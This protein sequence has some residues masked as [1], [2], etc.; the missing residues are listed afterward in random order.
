MTGPAPPLP[1]ECI[2]RDLRARLS[3]P[4]PGSPVKKSISL[5]VCDE[6]SDPGGKRL[7]CKSL[8]V[9]SARVRIRAV[10]EL[11][12]DPARSAAI[13]R[14]LLL[15]EQRHVHPV[16]QRAEQPAVTLGV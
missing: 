10:R 8:D 2:A 6:S 13:A 15:R 14:N 16:D 1:F 9:K 11:A 7:A 5:R 12:R 3:Y 4:R